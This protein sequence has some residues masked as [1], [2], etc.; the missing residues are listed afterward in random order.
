MNQESQDEIAGLLMAVRRGKVDSL[1]QLAVRSHLSRHHLS[2]LLKEQLGFPLRDFL[3][4]ARVDRGIDVLLDEHEV[5]RSQ[6]EAG[7]RS[8]SSYHRAFRRHTGMAPSRYR[9]QMGA[10]AAH[11]MRHQDTRSRSSE[12]RRCSG[13]RCSGQPSTRSPRSRTEP[14]TRWSSRCP[15]PPTCAPTSR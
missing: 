2:R 15:A 11:L 12:A 7:H 5:T 10:L 8:A 13:S 6:V 1:D 9:A 14:T 3:A 4:A